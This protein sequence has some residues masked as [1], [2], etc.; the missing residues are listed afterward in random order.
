MVEFHSAESL[1]ES[2]DGHPGF[3]LP[4]SNYTLDLNHPPPEPEHFQDVLE[5]LRTHLHNRNGTNTTVPTTVPTKVEVSLDRTSPPPPM[6]TTPTTSRR[7]WRRTTETEVLNG[8]SHS[9]I[10][11]NTESQEDLL[12]ETSWRNSENLQ[13]ERHGSKF[14]IMDSCTFQNGRESGNVTPQMGL[15]SVDPSSKEKIGTV[16]SVIDSSS[17]HKP[18]K[19]LLDS[20]NHNNHVRV[21]PSC[22]TSDVPHPGRWTEKQFPQGSRTVT[23]PRGDKGFGFIMVEQ[24]V[25][26]V[27]VAVAVCCNMFQV[28]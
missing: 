10:G 26:C 4:T 15:T 23:I 1:L 13:Y 8:L 20:W 27:V 21:H 17:F 24:K 22:H 5:T 6:K 2:F 12:K 14:T 19:L 11:S 9:N 25:R 18:E 16:K 7:M 3:N 28:T